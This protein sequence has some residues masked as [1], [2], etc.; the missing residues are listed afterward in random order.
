M[1]V[2][3]EHMQVWGHLRAWRYWVP[4][5][6]SSRSEPRPVEEHPEFWRTES[7]LQPHPQ[8]SG[9]TSSLALFFKLL[10]WMEQ[11]TRFCK[12]V[13]GIL[14]FRPAGVCLEA[15]LGHMV[16]GSIFSFI[17]SLHTDICSSFTNSIWDFYFPTFMPS[18]VAVSSRWQPFCS[19][20]ASQRS[21]N[22]QFPEGEGCATLFQ[23]LTSYL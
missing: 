21:L 10:W 9:W 14:S 2:S 20:L 3:K 22:Q 16:V 4:W 5:H 6:W 11:K 8:T 17:R 18:T 19:H 15:L 23:I 12:H 7:S 1:C 13:C